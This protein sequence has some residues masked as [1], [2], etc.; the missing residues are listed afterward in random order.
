[1]ILHN[2]L[3]SIQVREGL[4]YTIRGGTVMGVAIT[5]QI[6][7]RSGNS[8]RTVSPFIFIIEENHRVSRETMKRC[9]NV[10]VTV[11]LPYLLTASKNGCGFYRQSP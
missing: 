11:Q 3:M 5:D 4:G 10:P 7:F 9:R 2:Y 1:M 6:D 8:S